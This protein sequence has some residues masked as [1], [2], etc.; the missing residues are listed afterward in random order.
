MKTTQPKSDPVEAERARIRAFLTTEL[1]DFD[2]Q[3]AS[4]YA[5]MMLADGA[6]QA[7]RVALKKLDEPTAP[8]EPEKPT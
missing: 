7:T 4:F 2:N 6:A 1:T 3:K 8:A 5:Q